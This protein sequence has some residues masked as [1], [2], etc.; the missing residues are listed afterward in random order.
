MI[1]NEIH[2]IAQQHRETLKEQLTEPYLRPSPPQESF[3]VI[4]GLIWPKFSDNA[5][6][7]LT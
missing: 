4:H 1:T 2:S 5:C 7:V 6:V 3:F